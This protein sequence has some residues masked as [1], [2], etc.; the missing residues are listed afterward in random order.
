MDTK[1]VVLE[2][3]FNAPVDTIW[4]ALTDREK[5]KEWY[6]VFDEFKPEAGFEFQTYGGSDDKKYL[7]LFKITEAIPGKKLAY[8]WRYDGYPGISYLTF[9]LFPEGGKT[10]LK[11]THTGLESFMN[12]GPDFEVA[13]FN[14][15]WDHII[16]TSLKA[17]VEKG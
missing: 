8:S 17:F 4:Q 7:H 2:R 10:R 6:F 11:L 12:N 9:E 1:Q 15:G 5:M 14:A 16:N 3:T 13:S